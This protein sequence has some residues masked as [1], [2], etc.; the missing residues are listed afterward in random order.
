M[1][2][3]RSGVSFPWASIAFKI[4]SFRSAS[5]RSRCTR[6]WISW[7]DDLVEVAGPLL[8]VARD[9]GD[10]VPLVQ[11]LDDALHLHAPNLQVLRDTPQ[12]DLNRDV[13]GD[14]TL[15]QVRRERRRCGRPARE[16][17]ETLTAGGNSIR[18]H[19]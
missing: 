11:K 4:V 2:V 9:E 13:H 1:A 8:A 17:P 7:I 18:W 10:R 15:H 5:S 19:P 6:S 16:S 3:V 12:V 14:S